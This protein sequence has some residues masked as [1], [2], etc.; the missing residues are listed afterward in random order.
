MEVCGKGWLINWLVWSHIII[1]PPQFYYS[2]SSRGSHL[3]HSPWAHESTVHAVLL[4]V[5]YETIIQ[6]WLETTDHTLEMHEIV[7]RQ[8]C[9]RWKLKGENSD[10]KVG[11]PSL[12]PLIGHSCA[13][14]LLRCIYINC[15]LP[16]LPKI[17]QSS[18]RLWNM[19]SDVCGNREWELNDLWPS[20]QLKLQVGCRT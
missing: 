18:F 14:G 4:P 10:L 8:K 2:D 11:N 7:L 15:S 9:M 20:R 19:T 16:L 12:K 3:L 13:K 6:N 1:T 17:L 5:P